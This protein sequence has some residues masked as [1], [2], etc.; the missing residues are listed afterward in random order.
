MV[1]RPLLVRFPAAV[2]LRSPSHCATEIGQQEVLRKQIESLLKVADFCD[3]AP[4]MGR[5]GA[6]GSGGHKGK[7]FGASL[8]VVTRW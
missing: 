3:T 2:R 4:Q 6:H 7:E 8:E 5:L 1:P